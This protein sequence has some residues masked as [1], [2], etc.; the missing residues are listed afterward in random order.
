[1]REYVEQEEPED[2]CP[3]IGSEFKTWLVIDNATENDAGISSC[4]AT[5]PTRDSVVTVVQNI[6][7][8]CKLKI[9]V[10]RYMHLLS[11]FYY[12]A[13]SNLTQEIVILGIYY[14]SNLA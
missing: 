8:K 4:E 2:V 12:C 1:M 3:L 14:E 13:R 7:G 10:C 9:G 5:L 6:T 11:W